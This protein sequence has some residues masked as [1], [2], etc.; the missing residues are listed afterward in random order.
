VFKR[1]TQAALDA[2]GAAAEE[3]E[4]Q[5]VF[6]G[7]EQLLLGLLQGGGVPARVLDSAGLG[8][9][10]TRV[11]VQ[12]MAAEGQ[13]R[14]SPPDDAAT[15][16]RVGIDLEQVRQA[17]GVTV[18]DR[19]RRIRVLRRWRFQ[20]GIPR[21]ACTT[22]V[23]TARPLTPATKRALQLADD[24]AAALGS[25]TV[26]PEH[27]FLGLLAAVEGRPERPERGTGGVEPPHAEVVEALFREAGAT[28]AS[29]RKQVLRALGQP[30]TG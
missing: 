11:S 24:E 5:G 22:P 9:D 13:V 12:R 20:H 29:L 30:P 26:E 21:R 8:L 27:V 1:Y 4:R 16:R 17:S 3:A 6:V 23:G 7:L 25:N 28:A 14:G 2:V 19:P 18:A 15:L 10:A